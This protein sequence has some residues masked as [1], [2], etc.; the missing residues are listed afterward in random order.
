M[1][2]PYVHQA[3]LAMD[4][5]DDVRGPGAAITLA[6]CG[7]WEHSPPCPLAA[8]HTHAERNGGT[9][10][11]RV[12]FATEPENEVEVRRRIAGALRA[13][14]VT[15]PAGITTHWQFRGSKADALSTSEAARAGRLA[16]T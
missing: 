2:A 11:L 15:D 8:H 5:G 16:N 10:I 4:S 6:L 1:R 3:T 14:S 12:V 7:S 13:G 9:V